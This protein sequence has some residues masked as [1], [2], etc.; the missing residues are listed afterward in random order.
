M[1]REEYTAG[2][3][4]FR[5]FY[6]LQRAMPIKPARLR[7][8][9]RHPMARRYAALMLPVEVRG[10]PLLVPISRRLSRFKRDRDDIPF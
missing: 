8:L 2:R 5:M 10:D 7:N 3:A 1:T 6:G 9:A 4:M